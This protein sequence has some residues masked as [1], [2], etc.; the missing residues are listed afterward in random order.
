M[1]PAVSSRRRNSFA[2]HVQE[3]HIPLVSC[4]S[5]RQFQYRCKRPH[6]ASASLLCSSGFM[7][8]SGGSCSFLI[9][10]TCCAMVFTSRS[11]E[12]LEWP[13][14]PGTAHTPSSV[15][16]DASLGSSLFC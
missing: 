9:F 7:L 4:S 14:R 2:S 16:A 15:T 1:C 6:M 3:A 11:M 10:V 12:S 5:V 13:G 8:D